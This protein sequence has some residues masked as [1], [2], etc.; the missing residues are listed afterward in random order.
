[1]DP[2]EGNSF[3]LVR[4]DCADCGFRALIDLLAKKV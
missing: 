1:M 4:L 3:H 2:L